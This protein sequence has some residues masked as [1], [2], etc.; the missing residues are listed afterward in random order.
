MQKGRDALVQRLLV[1]GGV[2]RLGERLAFGVLDVLQ[3]VAAQCAFGET[4]K[5]LTQF[6]KACPAVHELLAEGSFVAEQVLVDQRRQA[7]QLHQRVLQ[8]RG[9]EQQL[10]AALQ[11]ALERLPGAVAG[12]VRVAQLVRF[13]DD[14]HVPGHGTQ[15]G[16]QFGGEL[17]GH[18]HDRLADQPLQCGE[19]VASGLLAQRN[20]IHHGGGHGELVVQLLRPLLAQA[21]RADDQ[22]PTA[23]LSPVLANH[24]RGFDGLAQSNFVRQQHAFLQWVSK[25][26]QRCLDLMRVQIDAGIE[27]RLGEAIY[28]IG[29]VSPRQLVGVVLGVVGGDQSV[30]S[31]FFDWSAIQP[32]MSV[33]RKRH[34]PP[35]LKAGIFLAAA[36]R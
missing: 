8:R 7:V 15:L 35:T 21:R 31:A 36:S 32:S 22:E 24:Q 6:V 11:R 30:P 28:A 9:G 5:T 33:A 1:V 4:G 25:G 26:E 19:H 13:V 2:E 14:H 29:G 23:A 20:G 10:F 34:V 3:H 12:A 18:D 27:Q 17:V 16:F